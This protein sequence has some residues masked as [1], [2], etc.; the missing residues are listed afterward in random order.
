MILILGHDK[1]LNICQ[2]SL[3]K[4]NTKTSSICERFSACNMILGFGRKS[5]H[6][7]VRLLVLMFY[8]NNKSPRA[9]IEKIGFL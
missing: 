4:L 8:E 6:K 5:D 2:Q 7:E 9:Y 3:T 1:F